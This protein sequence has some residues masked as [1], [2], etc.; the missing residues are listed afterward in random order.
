VKHRILVV[1]DDASVARVVKFLL[2]EEGHET[3]VADTLGDARRRLA[4]TAFD[5]VLT[6]LKLP[7]GSGLDILQL[8]RDS[9]LDVPVIMIT[10]FATV[11]TAVSAMKAGAFDYL[12]KPFENERLKLLVANA[13]RLRDL[14]LENI[15]LRT[16]VEGR[17][18][19]AAIVGSSLQMQKVRDMVRLAATSDAAV[20]ILGETGTGKE[21]VARAIHLLSGRSER[22][23]VAVNCGAIPENLVESELFGHKKG[24]FTGA[25]SDRD[26][27]FVQADTGTILLDEVTEMKRDLQVKLLRAIEAREVQP[28][29]GTETVKVDVRIISATNREPHEC[30][31]EGEFREDLYYRLNVFTLRI[32]PLREHRHDI[33]EVA[34]D[35]LNRR[36]YGAD[37]VSQDVLDLLAEHDFPGNVRELQNVLESGLILSQG[38][39]LQ[40]E[41]IADRLMPTA[42]EQPAVR[43]QIPDEG[44]SLE[45]VEKGYLAEVLRKTGGNQ[46]KAARL[47]GISRATL[48]YRMK[49]HGL[50]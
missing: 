29:G 20:M 48:L 18:G 4:G 2:E 11:S 44:V 22:P 36:G 10:A 1:D 49:K 45:G 42:T 46:S 37:V 24:S 28:V 3:V 26:G 39:T 17:Y 35:Y 50:G 43:P 16:E 41:H 23:F 12:T 31:R 6:D 13:L 38:K 30:V 5:L 8:V 34:T 7:D 33:P 15:R 27:R 40:P 47:L 32:P 19:L 14:K 9:G 25:V 21:L